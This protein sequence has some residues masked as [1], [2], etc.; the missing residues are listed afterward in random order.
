MIKLPK[1]FKKIFE[2]L[3]GSHLY[4]TNT[5][6]SDIDTRGVFIPSKEYFLGC[7][8]KIEQIENTKEDEVLFDLRKFLVLAGENNPNILELLFVPET[9]WKIRSGEWEKIIENR[10][11]FISTKA[12]YSFAGY[13]YS[14]LKR[15]KNH[16][17]WLLNPP[18]KKPERSDF[19][20]KEHE[21][22][23]SPDEIGAFNVFISS[24][25]EAIVDQHP[26]KNQLLEMKESR[27]FLGLTQM[28]INNYESEKHSVKVLTGLSDNIIE[29]LFKERHYKSAL[30]QWNSYQNWKKNRNPKRAELEEKYQYDTKH[31]SHL[32]R[33]LTEGKELLTTGFITLPRPDIDILLNIKN[34][35]WSYDQLIS[36]VEDIDK[37][38]D[39][40]Y[41]TSTLPKKPDRNGINNLC[42]NIVEEYFNKE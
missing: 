14:Q 10:Q 22:F 11:L 16:R 33:L 35:K 31:A 8:S 28:K 15:V 27:D 23:L 19:G 20:L 32:Y 18:K 1:D 25:L 26:L 7:Y 13:A 40:L 3:A 36:S 34:G 24:K 29:A 6:E 38:F 12:R 41:K 17:A 21:K 39:E 30:E 9:M 37:L 5:P 2:C 42:I 4:G